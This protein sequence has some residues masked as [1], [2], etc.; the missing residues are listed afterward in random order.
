M[1]DYPTSVKM[2]TMFPTT[3]FLTP[4]AKL[5][6]TPYAYVV[7]Q[8]DQIWLN[9]VDLFVDTIKR[10]GTLQAAANANGLGPIVAP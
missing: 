4:P 6:V 1:T 9:Y 8:G 7:A 2:E 10:D 3:T 5:A